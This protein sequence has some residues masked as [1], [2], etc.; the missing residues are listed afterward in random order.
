MKKK[1]MMKKKLM[2]LLL[3]LCI[4][5]SL[6]PGISI[7]A[8]A[9]SY[10]GEYSGTITGVITLQ[11]GTYLLN[12]CA[13]TGKTGENG[14]A[15]AGGA[16]VT[17]YIKDSNSVKAGAPAKLGDGGKAG[18]LV[19]EGATLYI[20][21]INGLNGSL[22]V[23]GGNGGN[24]G[25]GYNGKDEPKGIA[26]KGGVG[27]GGGGAAIGTDG[28]AGGVG[29]GKEVTI[30]GLQTRQIT[31]SEGGDGQNALT[32]G[33]V[34]IDSALWIGL[35]PGTGGE[36]GNGGDGGNG[37]QG[38]DGYYGG[39]GGGG[40]GGSAYAGAKLGTGGGAGGGGGSGGRGGKNDGITWAAASGAGGGG[41]GQGTDKN[42]GGGGGGS[43]AVYV[44]TA[45][46]PLEWGGT[47]GESNLDGKDGGNLLG[48][49]A[50]RRWAYGG[51]GG[52]ASQDLTN[53]TTNTPGGGGKGGKVD[54]RIS[55]DNIKLA[56]GNNGENGGKRANAA[57]NYT[58]VIF[59]NGEN[60]DKL[61]TVPTGST[62]G[63]LPGIIATG[64][65][66][67]NGW[68]IGSK[69]ITKDT[70][71]SGYLMT[72]NASFTY[73]PHVW[74]YSLL[75]SDGQPD[76]IAVKCLTSGCEYFGAYRLLNADA[77]GCAKTYDGL[78]ANAVTITNAITPVTGEQPVITYSCTGWSG[79]TP[80]ADAGDYTVTISL[81]GV[82]IER[83]FTI[84]KAELTVSPSGDSIATG[85][86]MPTPFVIY[87]GFKNGETPATAVT[88]TAPSIKIYTDSKKTAE[89]T[90]TGK[91][92]V[93][94]VAFVNG[95]GS[96]SAK[97][98]DIVYSDK[99]SSLVISGETM[100][101]LTMIYGDDEG[102]YANGTGYLN[103]TVN[104][105]NINGLTYAP[106]GTFISIYTT[107]DDGYTDARWFLNDAINSNDRRVFDMPA[108]D[109]VVRV[110]FEF[111]F[112]MVRFEVENDYGSI[113]FNGITPKSQ[114]LQS[115]KSYTL[116]ACPKD[117]YRFVRWE[118]NPANIVN[119]DGTFIMPYCDFSVKAVYEA[120]PYAVTA[121][122][123]GGGS[124]SASAETAAVGTEITL[125]ASPDTG[126]RFKEW[127]VVSGDV[128]VTDNVFVMPASN[129]TVKAVFEPVSYN[130]TVSGDDNGSVTSNVASAFAGEN[131]V[132]EAV[133]KENC[134]F[135]GWYVP[136]GNVTITNNQFVMPCGDVEV[137][138]V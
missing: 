58:T 73:S 59:K 99:D 72:V 86:Q 119:S 131:I 114:L 77:S 108:K 136:S 87:S 34:V 127:E 116:T 109:T 11:S 122:T 133:P 12:K 44:S 121:I 47:G 128:T 54:N 65:Q 42:G 1:N 37:S 67:F 49:G 7:T 68:Y 110:D 22:S 97:N 14:I 48:F 33:T 98:Y 130:V 92:G 84:S 3:A 6:L 30:W 57:V 75:T 53:G 103:G 43:A 125:N 90:E 101:K 85:A 117:G 61:F 36:A 27:A 95:T 69:K 80:P 102:K 35:T 15:I 46:V 19:P 78:P 70:K 18:I 83:K 13:I 115:R 28:G 134:I 94:P 135:V 82:S 126:Y 120:I 100:Y 38:D 138:G 45:I 50:F 66:V 71:T 132:L 26:V 113:K 4:A 55:D 16:T 124:A 24:G 23:S 51:K 107:P 79:D 137:Q 25:N 64:H 2:S 129:V 62:I 105:V 91:A 8:D 63:E 96:L 40:G 89:L 52:T 10:D 21:P 31:A 39:D 20:L 118:T 29:G 5:V 81:G 41:G 104:G 112:Y 106:A 60:I 111:P 17:L 32:P 123:D 76:Q 56:T 74:E 88:G 93:Y 9:A